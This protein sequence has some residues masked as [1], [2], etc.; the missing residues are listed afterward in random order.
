[1]MF[2][3]LRNNLFFKD[4]TVLISLVIAIALNLASLIG[5]YF[6]ITPRVESVALRYTIYFGI[7]LIGPWWQIFIFPLIGAIINVVKIGR[8]HV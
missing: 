1:M 8:A 2:S 6:S 5:L 3:G 4:R 7:D